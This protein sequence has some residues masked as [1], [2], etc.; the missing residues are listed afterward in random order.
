MQV[1]LVAV[2]PRDEDAELALTPRFGQSGVAHV[3]VEVDV[4]VLA[5]QRQPWTDHRSLDQLQV[6][7]TRDRVLG[8]HALELLA[9]VVGRCVGWIGEL[10]QAA[11]VHRGVATLEDQPGRVDG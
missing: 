6:P 2:Q 1:E 9:Q 3:V 11:D 8:A 4:I 7:G 10:E 5:H